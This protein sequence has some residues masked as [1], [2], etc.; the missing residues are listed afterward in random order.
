[1]I[2]LAYFKLL[3]MTL[4]IEKWR[5]SNDSSNR[6][7]SLLQS[8][9]PINGLYNRKTQKAL[10]FVVHELKRIHFASFGKFVYFLRHQTVNKSGKLDQ[11][12]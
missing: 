7:D 5:C 8:N 2:S 10:V 3:M 11:I 6:A 1:M 9:V 12:Y 4:C